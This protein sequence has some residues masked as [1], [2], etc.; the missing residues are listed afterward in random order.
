MELDTVFDLAS[1]TKVVATLPAIL[2]LMENGYI[3]LDDRVAF[4]LPEFG[5]NGKEI[6]RLDIY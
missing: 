1:L 2:K 5:K 6:L 3:R 4:F